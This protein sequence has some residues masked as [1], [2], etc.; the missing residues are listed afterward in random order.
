MANVVRYGRPAG[1]L[2]L[3]EA[4]DRLFQD[5]FTWPRAFGDTL[6]GRGGFG[7]DSNLYETDES[8]IMQV[9]LP[10]AKADELEITAQ[11]NVLT[12]RGKVEVPAPEGARGVWVG[13][14]NREFHQQVTLPGEVDAEQ[15]GAA[16]TDGVLTLTLPKSARAKARTIKIGGN[17]APAIEGQTTSA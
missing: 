4:V 8:Y 7:L 11:D 17:Q 6:S 14:T 16:Y 9:L 10:G 1:A 3:S 12:L 13:V 2:S 15:A 5:A